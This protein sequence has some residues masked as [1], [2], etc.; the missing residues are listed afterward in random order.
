MKIHVITNE[1][2]EVIATAP[3]EPHKNFSV[4]IEPVDATHKLHESV[5][6][7]DHIRDVKDVDEFHV[8]V[9]K[10]LPKH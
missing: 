2:G 9:R 1:K 7:P 10:H 3:A 5:E 6:V 4:R 8:H